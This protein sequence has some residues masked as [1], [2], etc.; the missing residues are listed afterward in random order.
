VGVEPVS[1][2]ID[3]IDLQPGDAINHDHHIMLFASWIDIGVKARL[4]EEPACSSTQ[5][6]A[7]SS[8]TSRWMAESSTSHRA[9]PTPRFATTSS[10]TLNAWIGAHLF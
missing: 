10:A 2:T 8:R 7:S 9:G 1:R 3:A 6:C 4:L 5:P